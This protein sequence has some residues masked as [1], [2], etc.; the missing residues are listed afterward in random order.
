MSKRIFLGGTCNGSTWRNEMIEHLKSNGLEYFNPVVDDWNEEVYENELR[1]REICD[2]CLYCI[3]PRMTGVYAIAETIDDSN[4]Q[5]NKTILVLLAEDENSRFMET[6]WKSLI[7][8]GKMVH[9]NGGVVFEDLKNAA[10]YCAV[11]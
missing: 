2:F 9:K 5:P 10:E 8:V 1:E 3:T 7:N 6:Q 11:L 4:K